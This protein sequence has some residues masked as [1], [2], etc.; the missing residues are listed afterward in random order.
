MSAIGP[1]IITRT[2]AIP[3]C[4]CRMPRSW[5]TV[6]FLPD[7]NADSPS[8]PVFL[9]YPDRFQKPNPFKADVVV[10]I[11][12]VMAKKVAAL[13]RMESQ[14][15]E[16]GANGGPELM[17]ADSS[18]KAKRKAAVRAGFQNRDHAT[19][20]QFRRKLTAFYRFDRVGKIEYAEAFEVCEYGR[21][22]GAAELRKLFPFFK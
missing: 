12:S 15:Y 8:N 11:D 20:D 2:T 22:P 5:S 21:Q 10:S 6:P 1:T 19:A 17:P 7:V 18:A 14:F 4:W 9:Y 3:A 16:G 13:E